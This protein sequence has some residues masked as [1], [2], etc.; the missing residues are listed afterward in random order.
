MNGS[1]AASSAW[2]SIVWLVVSTVMLLWVAITVSTV[3]HAA[4]AKVMEALS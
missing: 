1:R 3:L 2:G 4:V